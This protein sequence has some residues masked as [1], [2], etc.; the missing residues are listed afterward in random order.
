MH[1]MQKTF[2]LGVGAQMLGQPGCMAS[3]AKNETIEFGFRKEYH[4]FDIVEALNKPDDSKP[5][6]GRYEKIINTIARHYDDPAFIG[7]QSSPTAE[8]RSS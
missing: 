5:P 4:V 1:M 3:S 7:H 2:I 8:T 6:N